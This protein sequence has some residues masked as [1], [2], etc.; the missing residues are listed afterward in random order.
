[1][2]RQ[3]PTAPSLILLATAVTS[4][5]AAD[6]APQRASLGEVRTVAYSPN[7]RTLATGSGNPTERGTLVLWDVPTGKA[8]AWLPQPLGV[9][10]VAF[11]PDGEKVA[12][13]G[14]DNA[15]RIYEAR[16]ARLL[17]TLKGH[18]AVVN[19]LAFSPDGKTLA[20]CSLDKNIILWDPAK[21]TETHRLTGHTDWVLSIAFFPD[22]KSLASAGKD[23]TVRIWDVEAGKERQTLKDVLASA[24]FEAIA[25]SPDGKTI[26]SGSWNWKVYLWDV[27]KGAIRATL[28]GHNLGVLSLSFSPDGK[29]LASV[30]GNSTKPIPGDVRLWTMPNGDE[31]ARWD[32]NHGN[33]IWS[34]RFAPDGRTLAT[35]G[36]DQRV[37]IWETAT[38]KERAA[39]DN[40]LVMFD[41]TPP[42][43]LTEK[44][45]DEIW[46]ALADSDGTAVQ[47]AIGRLVRAP[48]QAAP[49]L[50]KRLKPAP[51]ADAQQAKTVQE[52]MKKLD[53]DDFDT[54]EKAVE[55]LAKLGAAA[56]PALQK[57]LDDSPSAEARQRISGLLEK[58]NKSGSQPDELRGVRA[59]EALE[60]IHTDAAK[61]LL[62][63]LEEGAPEASLTRE[64]AASCQ[65]LAKR[66]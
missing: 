61:E 5:Q 23:G 10:S 17:T 54:R 8:R 7:G 1:M 12:A 30:S 56:R 47:L 39:L 53:D 36:A 19:S 65:R 57:A 28:S 43:A 3:C 6:E 35:A 62:K 48:D 46:N 32:G 49:W 42:A 38:G 41:K 31:K 33:S 37:K 4:I 18:T 34:V 24:P 20:S 52:W 13:G 2:R 63:G 60:L 64:A 40:G 44:D 22:G 66:P 27:E 25:V 51:K 16:T 58:Q 59:I 26:A 15:V 21:G 29:T 55:E 14:W 45:L 11:T 50:A 9:C